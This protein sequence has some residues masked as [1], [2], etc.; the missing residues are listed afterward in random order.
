[1]SFDLVNTTEETIPNIKFK[2]I[3]ER[4]LGVDYSL[5][6]VIAPAEK[7]KELNLKYRNIRESTDILSFPFSS[8]EGEIYICPEETRKEAKKFD[9]D[10]EN[11]FAFLFV[12]GCAHL[13]GYDHSDKME[14]FEADLRKTFNI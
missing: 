13:K 2:E 4:S 10:Y 5:S 6:V 12:H 14:E 1:M 8:K 11:F 7:L 3:K 9:R